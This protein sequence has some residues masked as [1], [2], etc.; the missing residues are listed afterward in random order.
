MV[1]RQHDLFLKGTG[2]NK[3]L[4]VV[5]LFAVIG[6]GLIVKSHAA[7]P[8]TSPEAA[9]VGDLNND[10]KVNLVDLS[11]LLSNFGKTSGNPGPTPTPPPSGGQ[12][13]GVGGVATPAGAITASS[14]SSSDLNIS[15]GGS[16]GNP[17]V[18]DGKG[19]SVGTVN[20]HAD[21]VT[22]QNYRV[23]AT[24]QYGFYSEGTGITIQNNDIKNIHPSGDGDLNA[25]TWFGN[26][27]SIK[28]NTAINF[29]SGNPGDSHTDAIQT[30]V[31]SSHP[32]ASKNVIIQGNDFEGP[33]NP[34]RDNGIASIHQ[35]VM[36]EGL[37]AG[38][39][40]GGDGN[41]S[42]W[43][44][45]DNKFHDSWNQCIKLDGIANVSITRNTFAGS[46]DKVAE[47]D[48][49]TAGSDK[50]Y[51]DNKVTGSYG[52]VGVTITTGAGPFTL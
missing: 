11:M 52:S 33:D 25:I 24:G 34:S 45:A 29:V 22:V 46:S 4:L 30:W 50:Y 1:Q 41:P 39:N 5:A 3:M 7:T 18:Y 2:R 31:S 43:L 20:I 26:N 37:N 49:S 21:W 15:S 40:S 8:P 27:T 10:G 42:N 35:C 48:N 36:A 23:I 47:F 38:G 44:I 32:T 13:L 9:L 17:K 19:H 14:D 6:T 12:T 16:Q 51:S 28:Y